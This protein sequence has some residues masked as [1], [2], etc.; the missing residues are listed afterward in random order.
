MPRLS[1]TLTP[2]ERAELRRRAAAH[3]LS[4]AAFIRKAALGVSKG[5]NAD[6]DLW[7]DTLAPSR[8]AQVHGWLTKPGQED[9]QRFDEPLPF[10]TEGNPQP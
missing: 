7:W 3:R 4:L 8:K 10:I 9:H 1:V 6:P 5:P 2:S